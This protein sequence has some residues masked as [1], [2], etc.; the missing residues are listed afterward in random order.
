[1]YW[2][3][4]LLE[5][6]GSNQPIAAV[7]DPAIERIATLQEIHDSVVAPLQEAIGGLD[8]FTWSFGK[9]QVQ[10]I[11]VSEASG[12]IVPQQP[13]HKFQPYYDPISILGEIEEYQG[14]GLFV[15]MDLHHFLTGDLKDVAIVSRLRDLH[16]YLLG[17]RK[18]EPDEDGIHERL[19]KFVVVLGQDFTLPTDL[20][21]VNQI[22]TAL[23]SREQIQVA[24]CR[25]L[26][27]FEAR[28]QNDSSQ[29]FE[30]RLTEDVD[31]PR[32]VRSASGLTLA[33]IG[34]LMRR[35]TRRFMTEKNGVKTITIDT[36]LIDFVSS[37]RMEKLSKLGAKLIEP[38]DVEVAGYE[39]L[40]AWLK[41]KTPLFDAPND[42]KKR[43]IPRGVALA[44]PPGTGKSHTAAQ[45]CKTL[46]LPG[47]L[48]DI[49]SQL[50]SLVGESEK[51]IR[52]LLEMAES[53][54]PC[55]LVLDEVDKAGLSTDSG[56]SDGGVTARILG[57]LLTWLASRRKPVFV[58]V[59]MN[60]TETVPPEFLRAG[61]LD[62]VFF[63][64]LP[65]LSERAAIFDVH[66]AYYDCSTSMAPDDYL[67][68]A[69]LTEG[70]S[71]AE[72]KSVV[73][74]AWREYGIT[75]E[76]LRSAI[77]ATTPQSKVQAA[78]FDRIRKSLEGARPASLKTEKSKRSKSSVTDELSGMVL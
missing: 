21:C 20:G 37:A 30:N 28:A 50:G 23:P 75:I 71:G 73:D 63:V 26:N 47:I 43:P 40:Q 9:G 68:A 10:Q 2:S 34:G 24:I 4:T 36:R 49:G 53:L 41:D 58:I 25:S 15:L 29:R 13:K 67:E 3:Q 17:A 72:I 69:R 66:I 27:F 22:K 46:G 11:C 44:G 8:M 7:E 39:L 52:S 62:E 77:A 32:L 76:N 57:T 35:A 6:L 31:L 42:G 33:E 16:F 54:A 61:R 56:R 64:D 45:C 65:N 78:E 1:M 38:A 18:E 55:V 19:Y 59:T 74:S 70:F 60:R 48:V 12:A 14:N 5:I 51:N